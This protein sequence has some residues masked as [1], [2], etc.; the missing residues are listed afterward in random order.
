MS[1]M[2]KEY[3]YIFFSQN[4][5]LREIVTFMLGQKGCHY[6]RK[7]HFSGVTIMSGHSIILL[8]FIYHILLLYM[9]SGSLIFFKPFPDE[10]Y[11]Y[12]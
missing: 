10:Y 7:C 3:Q 8:L 6:F 9:M 4:P 1:L 2:F 12:L 5:P 11:H